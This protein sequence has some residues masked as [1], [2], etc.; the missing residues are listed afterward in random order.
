[1]HRRLCRVERRQHRRLKRAERRQHR[2]LKRAAP[3][4]RS[5]KA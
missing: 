4:H 2:H 3:L 5:A 1:V